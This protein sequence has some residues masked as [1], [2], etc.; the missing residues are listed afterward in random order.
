MVVVLMM[1]MLADGEETLVDGEDALLLHV[2]G[3][4]SADVD[5]G[6]IDFQNSITFYTIPQT[7]LHISTDLFV[8]AI[9]QMMQNVLHRSYASPRLG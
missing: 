5:V 3:S 8:A 6:P 4:A 2:V 1:M 9:R 7:S